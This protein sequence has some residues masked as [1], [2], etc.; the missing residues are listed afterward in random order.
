M[1]FVHVL[2]L[3]RGYW[4][5]PVN[6]DSLDPNDEDHRSNLTSSFPTA[7]IKSINIY[8]HQE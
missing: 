8:S 2:I 1:A 5:Y 6:L 3:P 7:E 4:M